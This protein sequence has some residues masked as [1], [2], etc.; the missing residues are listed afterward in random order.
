MNATIA[1]R[2]GYHG[3]PTATLDWCELNYQFSNYIA[4]MANSVSNLVTVTVAVFGAILALQENL[5]ARFLLG[6]LG[7]AS[8]GL[9]SFWFHATLLYEAQLGDEL[10]MIYVSTMSLWLLF[11]HNPGF[12]FLDSTRSRIIAIASLTFN[13]VFTWT[14]LHWRNPV[15]H[16]VVFGV[17]VLS[18]AS[19]V[20]YLLASAK[21]G[22]RI[23]AEKKKVI[24]TLFTS[25]VAQFVFAFLIWNLDNI[26][27]DTITHWK[28]SVGWPTAFL[29]EGH[30]WWHVFT[31]SGTYMKF[32]GMQYLALCLKD[33][34]KQFTLRYR[35]GFPYIKRLAKKAD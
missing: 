31:A 3:L 33:D 19:R 34:P 29:L 24:G 7:I 26:F 32:V 25:G 21:H 5:P 28:T 27:C 30:S 4:E 20:Y 6:Y 9:G 15:Y 14:Y 1:P 23:P 13:V 22:Q 2:V 10:P 18:T 11:D 35:F 17:L 12:R 8:V 16:Q